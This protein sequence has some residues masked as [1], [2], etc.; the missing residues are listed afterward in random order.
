[1]R[2]TNGHENEEQARFCGV[3]GQVLTQT[4]A[5]FPNNGSAGVSPP[6]VSGSI[7]IQA[8]RSSL[9]TDLQSSRQNGF[10]IEFHSVLSMMSGV[11]FAIAAG[12]LALNAVAESDSDSPYAPGFFWAAV[13]CVA[14]YLIAKFVGPKMIVGATTA[15]VALAGL[16]VLLLF[17]SSIEDGEI[18]LAFIILGLV[19][20]IA[21]AMPILRARPALLA[22]AL[23]TF[24]TGLVVAIMQSAIS[25]AVRCGGDEYSNYSDCLDDPTEFLTSV[26]QKSSTLFLIIGIVLLV[27]AWTLDR[28]DWPS[29]GRVFIGVGIFFEISGAFGVWQSSGDRTA[30]SILLVIAGALLLLVAVQRSR[31]TSLLIGAAGALIGIVSFIAAITSSNESS[32]GFI[33]LSFLAAVGIGALCVKQSSKIQ[34]I[35]QSV[36]QGKP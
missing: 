17:G 2:C 20:G 6:Q 15:F 35:L 22:S 24:G 14:A 9:I 25:D 31:T 4:T 11:L 28:K 16:S 12:L 19:Y 36:G 27:V 23:V 21:W 10:P 8:L 13:G 1:M 30:A 26:S 34:S 5:A 29:L 33:I 32:T 3:C 18:G 7:S